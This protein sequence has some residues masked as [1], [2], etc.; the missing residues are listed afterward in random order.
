LPKYLGI[1]E[2]DH[3]KASNLKI[4]C[5]NEV[6][7]DRQIVRIAIN[8][9]DQLSLTA[10]EID[11]IRA[12]GHLPTELCSR[13]LALRQVFPKLALSWRGRVSKR[14]RSPSVSRSKIRHSHP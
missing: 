4:A 5:P 9:H 14:S 8:S 10:K 2:A 12:D 6:T 3:G 11:K 13:D 7:L 1:A